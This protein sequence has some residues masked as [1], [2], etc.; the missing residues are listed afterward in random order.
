ME[1]WEI[2]FA[3]QE[4]ESGSGSGRIERRLAGQ[5][6]ASVDPRTLQLRKVIHSKLFLVL[7]VITSF[8]ARCMTTYA[9]LTVR[10]T[11]HIPSLALHSYRLLCPRQGRH[12]SRADINA[13]SIMNLAS[14]TRAGK[15]MTLGADKMV[16]DS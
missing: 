2:H 9:L 10:E 15:G 12:S 3:R 8:A 14:A 7:T 5:P 13:S 16:S 4:G 11:S 6:L 1:N